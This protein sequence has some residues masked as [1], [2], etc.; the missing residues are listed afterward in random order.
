MEVRYSGPDTSG[1][2][3]FLRSGAAPVTATKAGGYYKACDPVAALSSTAFTMCVFRSEVGLSAIPTLADAD[4]GLNRLYYVGQGTMPSVD[5]R[6]LARFSAVVP[7]VPDANYA[8]AIYGNVKIAGAGSY[9]LC[10]T[11]DD[12]SRLF[13]DGALL[14]DNEGLHGALEKCAT[15]DLTKGPHEIYI[16]GFQVAGRHGLARRFG[17][18]GGR[19]ARF[20]GG[21][22]VGRRFGWRGLRCDRG[23]EVRRHKSHAHARARPHAQTR[24]PGA[25]C[26][27]TPSTSGRTRAG[28][29]R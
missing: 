18:D 27:W 21:S 6:D 16:E 22:A 5:L 28:A 14:V 11:S 10:V 3:V 4:T 7:A 26:T 12:G 23:R 29:R 2:T 17:R 15:I 25:G 13:V 24:R 1:Q 20:R 19:T 8:W 9:D